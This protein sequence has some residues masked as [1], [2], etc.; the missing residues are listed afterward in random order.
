[1]GFI[2][3]EDLAP[4]LRQATEG[5][6]VGKISGLFD[7]QL[8]KAQVRLLESADSV[9][10]PDGSGVPDAAVAARIEETLRQPRLEARFAEYTAQ[11]RSR[12][13]VDIRY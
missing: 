3:L 11:L 8:N 5:L 7:M 6:D 9:S 4:V 10:P 1:M 13:L 2:A 12:A